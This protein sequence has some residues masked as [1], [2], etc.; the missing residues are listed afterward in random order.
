MELTTKFKLRWLERRKDKLK[1]KVYLAFIQVKKELM[2]FLNSYP[3]Q[4]DILIK[5]LASTVHTDDVMSFIKMIQGVIDTA[6][7]CEQ[8]ELTKRSIII[9][10]YILFRL[11]LLSHFTLFW[12]NVK[13]RCSHCKYIISTNF[14]YTDKICPYCGSIILD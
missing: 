3:G 8:D 14:L 7:D 6:K 5:Y 1:N 2:Q 11:H 10:K 4:P 9:S 13:V 12:T